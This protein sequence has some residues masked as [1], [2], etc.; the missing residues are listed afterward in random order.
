MSIM[1]FEISPGETQLNLVA[2]VGDDGVLFITPKID[3]QVTKRRHICIKGVK[4]SLRR[5][6]C[7]SGMDR[8]SIDWRYD[9]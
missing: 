5:G 6:F 2:L 7:R 9:T 1:S 8:D 3:A 4:R